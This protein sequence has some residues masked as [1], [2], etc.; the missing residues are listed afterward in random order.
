MA[1]LSIQ[2]LSSCI[3]TSIDWPSFAEG[4]TNISAVGEQC[5]VSVEGPTP[6]V[7]AE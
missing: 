2:S 3:A 5:G 4:S 6:V 7:G 1:G